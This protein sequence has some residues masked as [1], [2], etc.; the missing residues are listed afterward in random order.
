MTEPMVGTTVGHALGC[1]EGD[2]LLAAIMP[3]KTD[4][5]ALGVSMPSI[6]S[7]PIYHTHV[8]FVLAASADELTAPM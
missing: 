8:I 4:E 6:D 1:A 5:V 7:C 2:V 3:S